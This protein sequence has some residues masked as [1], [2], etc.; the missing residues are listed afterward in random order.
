MRAVLLLDVSDVSKGLC[1]LLGR[2]DVSLGDWVQREQQ[3]LRE[4]EETLDR[5][6]EILQVCVLSTAIHHGTLKSAKREFNVHSVIKR[7]IHNLIIFN[8]K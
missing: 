7:T 6:A 3:E 8:Q 4:V 1:S 2:L 5:A